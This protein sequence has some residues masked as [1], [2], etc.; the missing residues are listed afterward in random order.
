M[1]LFTFTFSAIQTRVLMAI[2]LMVVQAH[3]IS[4]GTKPEALQKQVFL[5]CF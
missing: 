1:T 4:Q 3:F 2:T 5:V